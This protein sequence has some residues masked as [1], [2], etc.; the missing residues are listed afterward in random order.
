VGVV[1]LLGAVAFVIFQ[2][3]VLENTAVL[4]GLLASLAA[5][6]AAFHLRAPLPG[7][8]RPA[9]PVLLWNPRSGGGK[10][11]EFQLVDQA[12]VRG[13]STVELCP[14]DDLE[15]LTRQALDDGAD[16]LAMAGGDGSQAIVATMA[17]DRGLP[18]VCVPA[19]T[20]NHLA[21][22]LGVDRDDVVGALD[23]LVAGRERVVD[24][25]EVNGRVFVNNVSLGLYGEAVQH[26]G[27]REAKVRTLLE[28]VPEVAGPDSDPPYLRWTDDEGHQHSQAAVILVSNNPY[29]LGRLLGGGTRPRLDTGKLGIAVVDMEGHH[30]FRTWAAEAFTVDAR[31]PVWVGIDGEAVQLEPP[32][33]FRMR[34]GALHVLIAPHHDGA[35]PTAA[36]PD[37]PHQ[38]V[39][40]LLRIA[41]GHHAG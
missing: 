4:V 7:A 2:A 18:Y 35:S 39:P 13:V 41:A 38:V 23:A 8:P 5:A 15:V 26:E 34:P 9:H 28:T 31:G 1:L 40:A 21:L 24:L 12:T 32:L 16:A 3:H 6:K 27:Y 22:D 25:A 33:R 17:A 29:R 14:G 11:T 20:R 36:V 10:A 37:E 19:G 30:H